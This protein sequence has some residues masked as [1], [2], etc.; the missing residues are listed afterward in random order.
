MYMHIFKF[1]QGKRKF[2]SNQV[3]GFHLQAASTDKQANCA[4][5]RYNIT[6][7]RVLLQHKTI[8]N[9]IYIIKSYLR[10]ET[11]SAYAVIHVNKL[12][13]HHVGHT[14]LLLRPGQHN[15]YY[16]RYEHI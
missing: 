6:T 9:I 13:A 5:V 3:R 1:I 16:G 4:S 15:Y 11:L 2:N 12:S 8:V 7:F 14:Y 10:P